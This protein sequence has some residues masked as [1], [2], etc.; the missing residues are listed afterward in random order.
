[1]IRVHL[2][3]VDVLFRFSI[4][5]FLILVPSVHNRFVVV[6]V[7]VCAFVC[8]LAQPLAESLLE[9]LLLLL[10]LFLLLDSLRPTEINNS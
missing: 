9:L 8:G 1:M 3:V 10:L 6:V 7:D 2:F 5:C 4:F